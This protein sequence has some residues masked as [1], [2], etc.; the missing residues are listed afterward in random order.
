MTPEDDFGPEAA[1][2][3]ASQPAPVSHPF[4]A[5][6]W[7]CSDKAPQSVSVAAIMPAHQ[8]GMNYRPTISVGDDGVFV[9]SGMVFHMPGQ[10]RVDVAVQIDSGIVRFSSELIAR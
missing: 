8:H 5:K 7:I 3:V 10:W 9:A 6:I 4:D 2:F 1:F